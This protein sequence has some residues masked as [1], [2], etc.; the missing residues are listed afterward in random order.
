MFKFELVYIFSLPKSITCTEQVSYRSDLLQD[1]CRR[2]DL[3]P[4]CVAAICRIVCLGLNDWS[5][6]RFIWAAVNAKNTNVANNLES[7]ET[8]WLFFSRR[9][10]H[11][12]NEVNMHLDRCPYKRFRQCGN[13]PVLDHKTAF[14]CKTVQN[15]VT[16][17][18]CAATNSLAQRKI[19]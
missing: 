3:S 15:K 16:G 12:R 10:E 2:G 6:H 9:S 13:C 11:F 4:R 19:N 8:A 1:Q 17:F 5:Y 14:L 18:N 7:I